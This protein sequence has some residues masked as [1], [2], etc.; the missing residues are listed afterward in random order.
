MAAPAPTSFFDAATETLDRAAVQALQLAKLNDLLGEVLPAN[1][2]YAARLGG[3]RRVGAW[4][5][6]RALPF[7]TKADIVEDQLRAPPFGTNLTYPLA[8]Y[9]KLHQTSG[10]TGK[11]PIR[12]LDTPESWAWWARCWG[13]VYRG[14]GIGAGDRV[15]YAFSFGPFIGFWAA[16]EG[17][18]TVGALTVP[19]GGMPTDQRL[20]A[21]RDNDVTVLCS[22]PTYALR[23][24]E[25]AD[26]LG[27]DLPAWGVRATVHAGEPGASVPSVR[28]RIEAAFGARCFDHTGMTE[29]GATGFTCAEQ[30]GVHLIES[31]FIFEVI[32]PT[33][34][35]P[36]AE[37]QPGE[38]VATNLGRP[39]MPLIRYRTGDLVELE[40]ATC[41]CG[42]TSAR[43]RNGILGRADDMLIVRGVNVFPS[44]IEGVLREFAEINEF[45]IEVSSRRSMDELRVLIDAR[46]D[47]EASFPDRVAER[48]HQ[49]L[50]L[51]VPCALA[52]PGSL[53]RFELKARRVQRV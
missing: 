41:A 32:D 53:P 18:A 23:M 47:V 42:R 22:T 36:V 29:L 14:A 15:F 4:E 37:G 50:L 27:L 9:T 21:M 26:E 52:P 28:A 34:C 7:T 11:A 1:S 48:L 45:R 43:L 39:G 10:T 12:W 19:G 3:S 44:A 5:E 24:A 46:P 30:K 16:Y 40:T 38:L 17:A 2:F 35:E 20:R 13:H 25:V 6:L 8:R 49:R 51:R 33:T 31:E